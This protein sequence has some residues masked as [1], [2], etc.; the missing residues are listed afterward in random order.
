MATVYQS[1]EGA[2]MFHLPHARARATRPALLLANEPVA[3]RPR[4]DGR[5]GKQDNSVE[6][7]RQTH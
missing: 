5:T 2:S 1:V 6:G 3:I 4:W 7:D